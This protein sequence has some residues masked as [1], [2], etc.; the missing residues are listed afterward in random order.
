MPQLWLAERGAKPLAPCGTSRDPAAPAGRAA[1]R[2]GTSASAP[3]A[4]YDQSRFLMGAS[5]TPPPGTVLK[6]R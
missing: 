6:Q 5:L 1:T 3:T 2:G 4:R